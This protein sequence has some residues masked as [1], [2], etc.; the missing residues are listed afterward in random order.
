M[1]AEINTKH[2]MGAARYVRREKYAWPGRYALALM[3]HD[4]AL[5]CPACVKAEYSQISQSWRHKSRD[6][7]RP[8][9]IV[10]MSEVEAPEPCAHCGK[11]I[12]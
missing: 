12:E 10:V 4:G 8:Y 1:F 9:G 2:P 7:W 5:L 3:M 6:G 11:G